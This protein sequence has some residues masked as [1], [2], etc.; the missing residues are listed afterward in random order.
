MDIKDI[1]IDEEY[2]IREVIKK[3]DATGKRI[4][5][6]SDDGILKGVITDGDIRRWI[7][8]NGDLNRSCKYIINYNPVYLYDTDLNKN[9]LNKV[10]LNKVK[11]AMKEN[12]VDAIPILSKENE[13]KSIIFSN[14]FENE[15]V[16]NKKNI[17]L[18]V[19]IMAGGLGTR[20]YPYTKILPKPLIPIGDIP[21]VERIINKFRKFGCRDFYLT[22]N[23]KK[24]MIKSYFSEIDKDYEVNY[25]EED[26]PLGTGG[27]LY[28]LKGK[29][30]Q[31]F[32]LSNCDIL[33]DEDY[34]R[35]YNHHKKSGNLVTMVC[36]IK[37][38]TIPYG[39]VKLNKYGDID[40]MVEKPDFS[41]MTNTGMYLVNP[42]VLDFISDNE[43]IGFPDIM[44]RCK[45]KG[46][47]IG[48]YPITEKCWLDMGQIDEMKEMIS[49]LEV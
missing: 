9:D 13:I 30:N 22:V 29:V 8:K 39:I 47:K 33:I 24:N 11:V 31:T 49:E 17:E 21:I 44:Q 37:N 14:D 35:I 5:L 32:F 26:K 2:N 1:I 23:H 34:E 38:I 7:L 25:I 18:P 27:S 48:V 10:D 15:I 42:K 28:L 6:V 20:L 19:V 3:I 16:I 46:Y 40:K 36:A 45:D 43:F 12:R 4:L 41:F